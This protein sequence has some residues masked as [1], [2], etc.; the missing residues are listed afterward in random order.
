M[1][2]PNIVTVNLFDCLFGSD[3]KSSVAYQESKHIR[4]V[5]SKQN[6]GGGVSFFT[7][8]NLNDGTVDTVTSKYKIGWL[9]EPACLWPETYKQSINNIDKYDFIMTYNKEYLALHP[10]YVFVP[11]GGVWIDKRDWGMHDKDELVSMLFGAKKQTEG[12]QLRHKI[13]DRI[14]RYPNLHYYGFAGTP[15]K[16][17]QETK[18][19]VLKDYK[20]SVVI[21]TCK[22]DNLF[23]EILLDCF[24]VGTIPVFWGASNVGDYFD[25]RGIITFDTVEE[26]VSILPVLSD[27]LYRKMLP[28]AK[29][30]LRLMADYAV[31][32]DFIF[33]NILREMLE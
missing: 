2:T 14:P 8:C 19:Q 18:L 21:E 17:A 20:F 33:N 6:W 1:P 5:R 29:E 9:R 22:D 30:N 32:E 31:T 3:A 23:T 26:L 28:A 15:T 11:Y 25:E 24:A 12:H 10:K 27:G 16:Y 7:D 4:Y 13:W